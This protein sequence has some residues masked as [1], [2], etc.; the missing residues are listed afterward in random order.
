MGTIG[1]PAG[2]GGVQPPV[3]N[4]S[5]DYPFARTGGAAAPGLA[6]EAPPAGAADCPTSYPSASA[7]TDKHRVHRW[8][9]TRMP[10]AFTSTTRSA[11]TV[12]TGT[13]GGLQGEATL[14]VA[15][16]RLSSADAI[17]GGALAT[18]THRIAVPSWPQQATQVAF[19]FDHAAFSLAA[20]E[21]LLLTLSLARSSLPSGIE[22]LY[23]HPIHDSVLSV[24]TTTPLP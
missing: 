1:A 7:A 16:H 14:C 15:L 23:D 21:R 3:Y 19:A 9:S 2:S 24:G 8:A 11:L 5:G 10:G 17:V 6:L 22:L 20:N 18:A 12:W 4:Y 13:V